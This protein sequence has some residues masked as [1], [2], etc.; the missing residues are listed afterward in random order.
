MQMIY[1]TWPSDL[2]PVTPLVQLEVNF[3]GRRAARN[4][5]YLAELV[6]YIP[7]DCPICLIGHSH[8]TRVISSALQFMAGGDV[9][10]MCHPNASA[11]GRRIRTVFAA[12]AI[13]HD[14]FNPGERYCRALAS[15]EC[16]LNL[17]NP[18]DPALKLYPLRRPL[19]SRALGAVGF[20]EKDRC[21]LRGWSAKVIDCDV[22]GR[23]G[24]THLWPHYFRDQGI[25]QAI[26]NFVYFPD[27]ATN[28]SYE[29]G[30]RH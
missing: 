23:V 3:L 26:H 20:T 17:Q 24:H 28:V 29:F 6:R 16:L 25:A 5:Y 14:W 12:S 21:K 19:A 11:A 13:D 7:P 27:V 30:D 2:S 18:D 1:L 8:G 15:T 4:G 10:G 22:S 9:Q